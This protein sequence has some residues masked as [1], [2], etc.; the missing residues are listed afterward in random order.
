MKRLDARHRRQAVRL[1]AS[2]FNQFKQAMSKKVIKVKVFLPAA[3]DIGWS[4]LNYAKAHAWH[5]SDDWQTSD[6]FLPSTVCPQ[7]G[8]RVVF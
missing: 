1:Q 5:S 7:T 8:R 6:D 4:A 2:F 3:R